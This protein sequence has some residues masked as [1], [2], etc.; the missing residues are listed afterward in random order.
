MFKLNGVINSR[1]CYFKFLNRSMPIFLEKNVILKPNEQK[2]I[3]VKAPFVDEISGMAIVK[4]LDGGTHSILL[5][6]LKFPQNKAILEIVN[7][8]VNIM[9][10]RPEEKI[11]VIDLRSLG[12]Y[13][14][15]HR[16]LEHNLSRHDRF[17]KVEKLCESFNKFAN[18]LKKERTKITRR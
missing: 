3:K 1:D 11:G 18:T 5:I 8:G 7:K 14:I 13:K 12:Y 2:L 9:I 6:K 17:E 4:I 15:K 16:I 10:F